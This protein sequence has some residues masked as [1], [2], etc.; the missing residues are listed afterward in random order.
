MGNVE[1]KKSSERKNTNSTSNTGFFINDKITT[2]S[3]SYKGKNSYK[4]SQDNLSEKDTTFNNFEESLKCKELVPHKF[5]WKE[6][7]QHVF[8]IGSFCNWKN[9]YEMT[10]TESND[11]FSLE[12]VKTILN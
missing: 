12:I 1:N 4:S 3:S 7:G 10:K 9:K 5:Y 11:Y 6:G 2:N 8:L